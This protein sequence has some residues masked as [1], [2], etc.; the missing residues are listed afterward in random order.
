MVRKLFILCAWSTFGF[1]CFVTLSPLGLRPE[2]GSA[3]F[4]RFAAYAL[5]GALFVLAYPQHFIKVVVLIAIAA[6]GLEGLQHL[7]PERHGHLVDAA[8]KVAGSLAGCCFA[9]LGQIVLE[10]QVAAGSR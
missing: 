9:K 2:T 8:M 1:V 10:S 5:L 4:D 6:L 3:G 7:T